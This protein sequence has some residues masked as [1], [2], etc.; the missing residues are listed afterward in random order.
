MQSICA[1]LLMRANAAIV[2]STTIAIPAESLEALGKAAGAQIYI[3]AFPSAF[4]SVDITIAV[5]MVNS[6][7]AHVAFSATGAYKAVM[8]EYSLFGLSPIVCCALSC[9]IPV[10]F[11]PFSQ[12]FAPLFFAFATLPFL[13]RPIL[14]IISAI[15]THALTLNRRHLSAA[16]AQAG[17]N[18]GLVSALS[19]CDFS[20]RA[21]SCTNVVHLI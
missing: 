14:M 18:S 19:H 10:V 2:V 5:H 7:K 8:I 11:L 20:F 1:P 6:Q 17:L 13:R 16:R 12:S 21:I 9:G 4:F 3:Q 15:L